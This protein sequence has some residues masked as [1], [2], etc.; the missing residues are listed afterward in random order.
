MPSQYPASVPRSKKR[1]SLSP[2]ITEL[3]QTTGKPLTRS[4]CAAT[5]LV[6][7]AIM[8][9]VA[10]AITLCVAGIL[11]CSASRPGPRIVAPNHGWMRHR[12]WAFWE[13][14]SHHVRFGRRYLYTHSR[15][16]LT[17][18]DR[19]KYYSQIHE[20]EKTRNTTLARFFYHTW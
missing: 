3:K 14:E 17:V 6:A 12:W 15:G 4:R 11:G 9:C 2:N 19:N 7:G 1:K 10:G 8:L 13:G 20:R 5:F 16:K 18:D